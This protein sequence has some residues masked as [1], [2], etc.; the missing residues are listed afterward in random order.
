MD[1][2]VPFR[3]YLVANTL[4]DYS[5]E[6]RSNFL[7]I[8]CSVANFSL[9]NLTDFLDL[10]ESHGKKH[11]F[12]RTL[13]LNK[14]SLE[15]GNFISFSEFIVKII[16]TVPLVLIDYFKRNLDFKMLYVGEKS[17]PDAF[18]I[19]AHLGL[20]TQESIYAATYL[21]TYGVLLNFTKVPIEEYLMFLNKFNKEVYSLKPVTL[22][23]VPYSDALKTV[24]VN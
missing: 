10:I 20:I 1:F 9:D 2:F 6:Q 18:S 5:T 3:L 15:A 13:I 11:E 19:Y 16:N 14:V 22:V 7:A 24:N 8:L 12:D 4:N 23:D 17:H 21:K